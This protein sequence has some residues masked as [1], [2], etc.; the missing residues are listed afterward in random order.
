MAEGSASALAC[1]GG[2][3]AAVEWMANYASV[4]EQFGRKI[5]EKQS[6]QWMIANS[7]AELEALTSLVYRTAWMADTDQPF[8]LQAGA[9]KLLGSEIAS[10]AIDRALQIHGAL[11]YSR[12]FPI[13]RAWRDARI[14]EIF[15]GTNEI[16]RS[17]SPSKSWHPMAFG[18]DHKRSQPM[19]IVVC[20]KQVYD[21][22]T[23]KISRSREELD[24]RL[25]ARQ[26]NPGDRCALE[27]ALNSGSKPEARLLPS[28]AG[29]R[30]RKRS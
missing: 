25:A 6:I 12:D 15:E 26:I 24:L 3:R 1:V 16:Q 20:V 27:Q 2:T 22:A 23:V 8:T 29:G 7:A 30:M 9:C 17:S 21:P 11:G 19:R 4:R 13:E 5:G 14:G 18:C 28:L 10:R